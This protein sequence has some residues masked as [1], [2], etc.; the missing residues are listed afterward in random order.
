MIRPIR[1]EKDYDIVISRI[2][3]LLVID[4][5]KGTEEYDELDVLSTLVEKYEDENYPIPAPDPIEA[6][7]YMMEERG[8]KQKDL[9]KMIGSKSR[10]SEILNRK[11]EM[12]KKVIKILHENLGIPYEVLMA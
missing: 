6:I 5:R 10:I 7:K 11:R 9:G 8:L 12:T 3:E 4:P 1:T 2:D